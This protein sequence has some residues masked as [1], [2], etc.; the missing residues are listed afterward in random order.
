MYLAHQD[1]NKH[2]HGGVLDRFQDTPVQKCW[3]FRPPGDTSYLRFYKTPYVTLL[4]SVLA[5]GFSLE[6]PAI[7]G[8]PCGDGTQSFVLKGSPEPCLPAPHLPRGPWD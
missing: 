1:V 4:G 5:S 2:V 6:L 3:V 7:P 8:L